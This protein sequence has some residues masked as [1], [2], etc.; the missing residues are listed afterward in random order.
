M[1][2]ER[3]RAYTLKSIYFSIKGA[4]LGGPESDRRFERV[5][6]IPESICVDPERFW[7][8]WE[9]LGSDRAIPERR[10]RVVDRVGRPWNRKDSEDRKER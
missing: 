9:G 7:S 1:G 4:A 3:D 6:F 2:A 8:V 10:N 5:D